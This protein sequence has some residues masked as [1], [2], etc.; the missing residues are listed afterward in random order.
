M[1]FDTP[2]AF[3]AL[4]RRSTVLFG[5][6]GVGKTR[7][8]NILR[9]D[10]W[11]HY[12]VDYRIGTRYM[13]EHIV[14][15]FKTEAMKSPLLRELLMSDSIYIAS[16]IT[17]DNLSPL[18]TYLGKPGDPQRGGIAFEEYIRRQ[19][20][21]RAAEISAMADTG[22]FIARAKRV[23]GYDHFLCDT[24]GSLCE[25]VDPD[26]ADDPIMAG[27][28][29]QSLILYI[30]EEESHTDELARRFDLDPKPLYYNE[31]FLRE[32]WA[33]YLEETGDT[34]ETVDP[35]AFIRWSY[36]RLLS[37]R[38]PRYRA[39]AERWGYTATMP[40]IATVR[41]EADFLDLVQT[42]IARRLGYSELR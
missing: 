12:S 33:A 5:M 32:T 39:M 14:D 2:Q 26:N 27:L 17:F 13:G 30:R 35:D 21:H 31:N 10:S 15:N 8:A 11:F 24:S 16:N 19:R 36:R 28:T 7:I 6:S 9:G 42:A 18:S 34:P 4:E 40:E 23:Y 41:D 37:W 29:P 38:G 22:Q 20:E 25:V 3:T 1:L